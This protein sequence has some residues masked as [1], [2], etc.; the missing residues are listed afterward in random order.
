MHPGV[1]LGLKQQ[2]LN[3]LMAAREAYQTGNQA[4]GNVKLEMFKIAVLIN[5][6]QIPDDAESAI[7]AE[8]QD[9][10]SCL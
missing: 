7:K 3:S 5:R 8:V 10:Q 2:L 4:L 9:L 6:N 1:P